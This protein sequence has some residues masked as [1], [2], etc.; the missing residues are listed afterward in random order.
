MSKIENRELSWIKFNTRVLEEAANTDNPILE[1]GKFI[2]ICS[3]NLDEFFMV[4]IG[5]L[6]RNSSIGGK[7]KKDPSGMTAQ[8][9]LDAAWKKVRKQVAR[10]Y[11]LLQNDYLPHLKN[12]G[13]YF[14]TPHELSADQRQFVSEYFDKEVKPLLTP[15]AIDDR[16]PFP[17]LAAKH[18]HIAV[19]LP[20]HSRGGSPRMALVPMPASVNRVVML[21]MGQ[22]RARGI[23]LEDVISMHMDRVFNSIKPLA[24]MPFRIT[25][26]TDFVYNDDNAQDLIIEMRKNL[27]QRKWGKVVR[28]E[29]EQGCDAVLLSRLKKY[30]DV[31]DYEIIAVDGPLNPNYFMKQISSLEGLDDLRFPGFTPRLESSLAEGQDLFAAMREGDHFLHHPYDSFEPVVRL[32]RQAAEDPDVLAIKQTLYRVSGKS[33]IVAALSDAAKAGK[34]VTVLIEVRARFDEE[35]NINWCLALEKAGCQVFYG[36]PNLKCHSKITLIV[37]READGLRNYVHL[38][39]GNYNDSTAKMYT[40]MGLLT[41]DEVIGEDAAIFFN[42]ITGIGNTDDMKKLIAA[43]TGM[44]KKLEELIHQEIKNAKEGMKAGI[45]AKMNSLL[46]PDIVKLLYKAEEAGVEVNLIIRGICVIK[47]K[48]HPNLHVRSIVG[49]FLEHARVFIFENAGERLVYLASADWMPRNLDK[50]VELMF[51]IEDVDIQSR[52][53]ATL[54][55]ELKDTVKAWEKKKNGKYERVERELPLLNAQES[56]IIGPAQLMLEEEP[57]MD[58][59]IVSE[60]E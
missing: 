48:G 2:S 54:K 19:M 25:R 51:P 33:P 31:T 28:L 41:A 35:N 29:V 13:I 60:E 53:C 39:T 26:N 20:S 24:I 27:K 21:P 38:S 40:D 18:I 5:T 1:R 4:R 45:T 15:R 9:Q 36:V 49:R 22:G 6:V 52:I 50:R 12:A 59:S 16:R 34:Q 10:Q 56:R 14:L 30:L 17:L 43:P 11:E 7:L 44:R 37:R 58:E 46:D 3:S 47:T 32:I 8:E 55:D 23:L 57:V 42:A